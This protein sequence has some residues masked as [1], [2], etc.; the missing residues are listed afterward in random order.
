[1]KK[2]LVKILTLALAAATVAGMS[3][4][5][6]PVSALSDTNTATITVIDV[7]DKGKTTE[8]PTVSAYR[9]LEATYNGT[10]FGGYKVADSVKSVVSKPEDLYSDK[11]TGELIA[12]MAAAIVENKVAATTTLTAAA[13]DGV[14][15]ADVPAGVYLILVTSAE[16]VVYNP[17]VVS[18]NVKGD[19]TLETNNKSLDMADRKVN[20]VTYIKS[21]TPDFNK[22]IVS[23]ETKGPQGDTVA[24]GDRVS[25]QLDEMTIPSYSDAYVKT[26]ADDSLVYEI[27]DTLDKDSFSGINGLTVTVGGKTVTAADDTFDLYYQGAKVNPGTAGNAGGA[28]TN[29]KVSFKDSFIRAHLGEAVQINYD[30]VFTSNAT[31]NYA[32]NKNVAT[33]NYSN[34]PS[35]LSKTHELTDV[36]YHYTF[37]I[38]ADIDAKAETASGNKETYELNKVTEKR[39]TA[40][41][42]V[43]G[44]GIADTDGS[45]GKMGQATSV[46]NK[47][48]ADAEFTLYRDAAFTDVVDVTK[49]DANGHITFKGLDEGTYYMKETDTPKGTVTYAKDESVYEITISATLNATSGIMESYTISTKKDGAAVGSATYTNTPA[50]NDDYSV[51]NTIEHNV[52]QVEIVNTPLAELPATGGMGTIA[53]TLGAAV[54]MAGFMTL[55]IVNK[56]KKE[57][58]N[59]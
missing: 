29:F 13:T 16:A 36:T 57:E 23:A 45:I 14:Y 1:M 26:S 30:S 4:M 51:T 31:L 44:T 35:D 38:D 28:A 3:A 42:Y 46:S 58:E 22:D 59:A 8:K 53:I 54:G 34:D 7:N 43:N 21:E 37:G 6:M 32:E 12:D 50:V 41:E 24:W 19:N 18:V 10:A 11:I 55:Y 15:T 48:L 5:A 52:D 27:T 39:A 47:P 25:F 17:G 9:V 20:N 33:L 49:S 40:G 56:K 2:S